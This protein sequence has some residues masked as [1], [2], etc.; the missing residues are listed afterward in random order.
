M[1]RWIPRCARPGGREVYNSSGREISGPGGMERERMNNT[2]G[3]GNGKSESEE[4]EEE[5]APSV[6][7]AIERDRAVYI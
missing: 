2:R 1:E 3:N 5:K 4:E 6:R 7:P